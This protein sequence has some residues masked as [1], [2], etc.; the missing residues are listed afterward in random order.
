MELYADDYKKIK[1]T[2]SEITSSGK[3]KE[4]EFNFDKIYPPTAPQRVI[5]EDAAKPVVTAVFGGVD[6]TIF[7]YGQT[8]SGKTHT[9][10]GADGGKNLDN[11]E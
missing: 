6:G 10:I 5:Y 4:L 8:G 2:S 9:M 11:E 7:A 1:Y 3:P